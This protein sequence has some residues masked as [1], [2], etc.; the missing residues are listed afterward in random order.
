MNQVELKK[1]VDS[2]FSNHHGI[3]AADE[4]IPTAGKRLESIRVESTP[5]TRRK[6]R[7][8]FLA[9]AGID[10]FLSGVIFF[11]ETFRQNIGNQT[12]PE[13]LKSQNIIPGIKVDKGTVELPG[14]PN[15]V[16][17]Q[18][19][20]GLPER[21]TEYYSLGARF[22]KWRAVISIS[23]NLPSEECL[24]QNAEI[25][26]TY[27]KN[28]IEANIVPI[29]EPE[30]LLDGNHSLEKS[31]Q[32]TTQTLKTVFEAVKNQNIPFEFIILKTSM[33][34]PGNKS[35]ENMDPQKI[36]EATAR[37]LKNSV[38]ENIGGVVFLSGGQ[39]PTEATANLNEIQKLGPYP[40]PLSFSYARALQGPS[41]Q[42]WQGQ[43]QNVRQAQ[44]V[45]LK[46]LKLNCLANQGKYD[47]SLE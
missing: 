6:Y 45:F 30:V 16:I 7:E 41:L 15:E 37:C 44:E 38:P 22:A 46:R 33:V 27:A 23:E 8:I 40:R 31:E 28:C 17:T 12:F 19:L 4:S 20:E 18:G 9:T 1:T 10:Q 35:G 47:Q 24:K 14:H 29:L 25:L 36:A 42:I 13:F 43:D 11:D 26:A 3:L 32:V 21:L 34:V 2:I 5:E 39:T